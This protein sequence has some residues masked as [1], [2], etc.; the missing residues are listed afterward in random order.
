[1]LE[2]ISKNTCNM[3]NG[4][5]LFTCKCE[6]MELVPPPELFKINKS[7]SFFAEDVDACATQCCKELKTT[8]AYSTLQGKF[9]WS[10]GCGAL[11]YC[12]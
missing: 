4:G 9:G 7:W 3:I 8:R 5:D 10:Y 12:K 2:L 1:M 11:N 6:V